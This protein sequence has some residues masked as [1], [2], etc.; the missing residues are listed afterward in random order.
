MR[1]SIKI[2]LMLVLGVASGIGVRRLLSPYFWLPSDQ[3]W[4][5]VNEGCPASKLAFSELSVDETLRGRLL[6]VPTEDDSNAFGR[7]VCHAALDQLRADAAVLRLVPDSFAC[8]WLAD[9]ARTLKA[10]LEQQYS[11]VFTLGEQII[12]MGGEPAALLERGLE[13]RPTADSFGIKV[14]SG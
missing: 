11:P 12:P 14:R 2:A 3:V 10:T 6:V 9:D 1:G 4:V 5:L 13:M 7:E 8:K